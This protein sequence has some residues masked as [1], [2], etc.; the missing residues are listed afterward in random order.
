M[1]AQELSWY[2]LWGAAALYAIAMVV[3][4]IH[5]SRVADAKAAAKGKVPAAVGAARSREGSAPVSSAS[6]AVPPAVR[7]Q[8]TGIARS[9]TLVGAILNGVG[10]AARGVEAG[11]AP[12]S[13]MYEYTITGSFV[14][15][16]VFLI[17]QSRRDVSYLAPGVTG[18]ATIALGIGLT[19]LYQE[20]T[21]LQP[22]LQSFWLVIH[23]SIAII[24]TGVFIVAAVATVLQLMRDYRG[25]ELAV[26][27]EARHAAARLVRRWRNANVGTLKRWKWLEGV[28]EPATLEALAFR[29]HA[30][31][32]VLWTF[33]VMAGAVWAEHAWGRYWGWDPKEVWSFVIWVIYAAY[34]H[35]RTTQ[36]WAGRRSAV[37]ALAGFVAL[38]MNFTVVNLYFQGM[39]T[40]A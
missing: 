26:V 40:Y 25:E 39:H 21:G 36:G 37:L 27:A 15:A 9:T 24:S 17:V 7:S 29:L 38:I 2:A 3:S 22:A 19:T 20:S 33:T 16:V 35:A 13:T 8:A 28:P 11:H 5:L 6:A 30:V 23:V 14:A 1:N 34:L 4:S 12:W 31:G 10:V 18:F 32:F